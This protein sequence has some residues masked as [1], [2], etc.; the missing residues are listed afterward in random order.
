[1]HKLILLVLFSI[2]SY[3]NNLV[4]QEGEIKA[5]TE[6]LG[7]SKI[8]PSTKTINSKLTIDKNIE[9]IKGDISI[10]SLTLKSD[11]EDRDKHMYEVLNIEVHP[12][13][14]LNII[15]IKKD[16]K[17]G[18]LYN[19]NASLTLNGV[20]KNIISNSKIAEENNIIN[21]DGSFSI[22]LTQFNIEPPSLLFLTVRDQID[23]NYNL[24]YEE[25]K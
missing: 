12:K 24:S 13:I 9:S 16:E 4:L 25:N 10:S 19:I 22:K 11:N 15:D 1:M 8:D 14:H 6:I 20:T 17:D 18:N 2:F 5:H 3:A 7:D 21:F 23:I